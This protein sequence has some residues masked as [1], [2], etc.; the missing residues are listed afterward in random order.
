[1]CSFGIT[2][3]S[4]NMLLELFTKHPEIEEAWLFGSRAKGNNKKG[5]DIDLAIK[6]SDCSPDLALTVAT[7]ANEEL[8][9][10]YQ[11]DIVDYST[12]DNPDLKE[13]IDRVGLLFYSSTKK[14]VKP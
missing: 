9:I 12:I 11:I 3:K 5:S 7:I 4:Y 14:A 6:G 1:M 13:H 8:P 2:E 10:P